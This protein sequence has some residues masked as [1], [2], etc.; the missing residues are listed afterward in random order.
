MKYRELAS[1]ASA[2]AKPSKNAKTFEIHASWEIVSGTYEAA[3]RCYA[4]SMPLVCAAGSATPGG[5]E[6]LTPESL[7]RHF[8]ECLLHEIV[9]GTPFTAKFDQQVAGTLLYDCVYPYR[10]SRA[11]AP[12]VALDKFRQWMGWR[13]KLTRPQ[14]T[15]R[16]TLCFRLEDPPSAD[17]DDW[18]VHFL[19]AAKH[20]PSLK[21]SLADYWSLDLKARANLA[22]LCGSDFERDLLLALGH[23]AR[24]FPKV[25]DGLETAQPTGFGLTLDEAYTFLRESAWILE[26]AGYTVIV[27]SWWTPQ[28]RRRANTNPV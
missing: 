9:T 3:I 8:S 25:W 2:K 22:R 28:G 6:L 26:D 11:L 5:Q 16:F 23:A 4:A 21:L 12:E 24:I 10:P 13:E 1:A 15:V 19:V 7:L 14:T 18:R 20:D 17:V 27:P